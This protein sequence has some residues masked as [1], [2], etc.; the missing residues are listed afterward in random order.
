[1]LAL[2]HHDHADSVHIVMTIL[3]YAL[4]MVLLPN[5]CMSSGQQSFIAV[6]RKYWKFSDWCVKKLGLERAFATESFENHIYMS[7]L[8][9]TIAYSHWKIIILK[10]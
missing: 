9:F 10:C 2:L 4:G 6:K 1:M 7:L 8:H 3:C 5:P